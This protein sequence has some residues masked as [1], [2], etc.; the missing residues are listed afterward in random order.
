MKY[1]KNYI[2]FLPHD[3]LIICPDLLYIVVFTIF[4]D[5]TKPYNQAQV[6]MDSTVLAI[7]LTMT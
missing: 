4:I 1:K 7:P 2:V 3:I 6:I 5:E